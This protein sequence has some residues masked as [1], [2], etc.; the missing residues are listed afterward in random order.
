MKERITEPIADYRL[1]LRAGW[2]G[3]LKQIRFEL[4]GA[5][6]QTIGHDPSSEFDMRSDRV[7]IS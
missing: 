1:Q 3:R 2:T 7:R 5:I 6:E 4:R